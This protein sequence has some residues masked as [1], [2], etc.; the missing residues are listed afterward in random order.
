VKPSDVSVKVLNGS[1][2]RGQARTTLEAL[3]AAGFATLDAADADR[4]DYSTT[5]VRYGA[6]ARGKAQLVA[7]YLGVGTLVSG[8]NVAGT[9]VT[10]V[11]GRDFQHVTAPTSAPVTVATTSTTTPPDASTT[12]TTVNGPRANPGQTPGVAPQPLVGCG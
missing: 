8:D 12:P 10:I 7:A 3:Q 9:D 6:G 5:E 4:R 11:L 1:G 2:V